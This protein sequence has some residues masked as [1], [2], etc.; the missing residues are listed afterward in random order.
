MCPYKSN[1]METKLRWGL[2]AS[3]RIA[4]AFAK[5][6]LASRTGKL[7]AVGSRSQEKADEFAAQYDIPNCHGSYEALL[8]DPEVDAVYI[9]TPHPGHAEWAIKAAEAGNHILCVKP[10]TMNAGEAMAVVE[11]ARQNDVFLMEAFMY[12]CHPQTE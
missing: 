1:I 5:G 2:L 10:I 12:R 3:G 6:V 7:V 8:A 9:S 4:N 11:A